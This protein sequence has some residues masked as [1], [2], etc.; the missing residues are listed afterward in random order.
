MTGTSATEPA[1]APT[2]FT[3]LLKADRTA[4]VPVAW[5]PTG[6]KDAVG[7]ARFEAA[8]V[9]TDIGH[10]DTLPSDPPGTGGYR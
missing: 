2:D 1:A 8:E 4:R 10:A 3:V 7:L 5:E 9:Q 6:D